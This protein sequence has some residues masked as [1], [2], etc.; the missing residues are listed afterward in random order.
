MEI[1]YTAVN[2]KKRLSA[3]ILCVV[4]LVSLLFIKLFYL[5]IIGGWK[6]KTKGLAQWLRDLPITAQR[7]VITDRNGVELASSYTTYNCYVRKADIKDKNK[8]VMHLSSCLNIESQEIFDKLDKYNYSEILIASHIEKEVVQNILSDYQSGIFFTSTTSRNYN[9]DN[10][11]CQILGFLSSDGD[12]QSGLEKYYNTYLKGID[13]VSL[14]ETDL[15]GSSLDNALSYYID[16]IDGLNLQLTIDFQIQAQVEK[17]MAEAMNTTGAKS[18]SALVM[19]PNTGEIISVCTLPSY[20][21]NEIDRTDM[22]KLNE[23]SRAK[24]ITDTFEPGSTFKIIVTAIALQEGLTS[25][26]S[27]YYCGGA[28]VINGVR[29][30]CS[31][32]SGH[33]SQTLQQ[34]LNNS[35]NCVF[36]DLINQIGIKK[37]YW[38]L[39]ELGF[40]TTL[41]LDFP[42]ETKAVLMPQS[43]VTLP[44]LYRMGFGQTIAISALELVNTVSSIINGGTVMQPHLVKSINNSSGESVYTKSPTALKKVFKKEVSDLINTML[45]EVV[46]KGGGKYARIDGY[47][48]AGKTGTAQKYENN[49]IAQGKYIASFIGYYP[50]DK[51]EYVVYVYVD[52]PQGAYYGGVV[53]APIAKSIFQKIIDIRFAEVEANSKYD[54]SQYENT[55]ELPSLIGMTLSEAGSTLAS[56]NLQYL[57]TGGGERVT[58]HISPPGTMVKEGDIILL[59]FD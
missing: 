58:S 54:Q 34:G 40:D 26:S 5:Q 50:A 3:I 53:A 10:M 25:R 11:L 30:N 59:V 8:V 24:T 45:E 31:R 33:G 21:L 15:K 9:Y 52:E 2:V 7:G 55:I 39:S 1:K 28:R 43:L 47:N 42:G 44:D 23:L 13:G 17:I 19:N 51:P 12:G 29:I 27:C 35:C 46:S 48:I 57:V 20:N 49:A 22:E 41:G 36:M 32:R 18:A 6:L 38:Y 56:L 4:F 14:V 37:F 16:S